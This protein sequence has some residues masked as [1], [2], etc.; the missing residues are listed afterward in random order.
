MVGAKTII[1]SMDEHGIDKSVIFGFPWKGSNLYYEH[2]DYIM[3]AVARHPDRL[4]GLC[5]FDPS[6]NDA[7]KE[8]NRCI[9]GGLSGVG[10]LAFYQ[11]ELNAAALSQLSPIMDLC[12]DLDLPVLL[13]VNEPIGHIYPGKAPNTL[14]QIY[15][16]IKR[17]QGNK[18]ILAH[19]GGG[20]F[21]YHLLKRE[22]KDLLQNV[23]VDTAASPFL[24]DPM[25][26]K[27]AVD[28]FG[29][30]KVLFGSD[31]PLISPRRYFDEMEKVGLSEGQMAS[32]CGR[33]AVKLLKL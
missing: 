32:I 14:P 6:S 17:F 12:R 26:Y 1:A 18:I 10:E 27:Y 11:S 22:V 7:E 4:V 28:I 8:V 16:L 2:N 5:C 20:I 19:W 33:N 21:I 15:D 23:A 3:N 29:V 24:Y 25:V 31:F 30:D 9:D 13:H